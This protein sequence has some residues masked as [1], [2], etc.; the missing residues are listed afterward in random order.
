MEDF[1]F[2][3]KSGI[4]GGG[5]CGF[6]C[7]DQRKQTTTKHK[8]ETGEVPL[9]IVFSRCLPGLYSLVHEILTACLGFY[10]TYVFSLPFVHK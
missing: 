3:G 6:F 10:F 9:L 4:L 7:F 5:V 1:A 2:G 8:T